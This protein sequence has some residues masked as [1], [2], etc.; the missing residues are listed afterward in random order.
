MNFFKKLFSTLAG[1]S[2]TVFSF[3][4]PVLKSAAGQVIDVGLPIALSIVTDLEHG[5]L[6]SADKR[7][8][9]FGRLQ[10]A[11]VA[12]GYSAAASTINLIIEMAVARL[13]AA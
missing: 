2:K 5:T 9:A 4:L 1:I 6:P 7:A 8:A 3:L 11:L 12:A 13:K 10:A